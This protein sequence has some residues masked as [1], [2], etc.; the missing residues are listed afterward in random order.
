M[1]GG[2]DSPAVVV[3]PGYRIPMTVRGKDYEFDGPA[4]TL[5]N[6][7]NPMK[8]CGPFVHDD[9]GGRPAAIFGGRNK[10]HFSGGSRTT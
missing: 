5:S 3:P 1:F 7:K 6:M 8:G 10:L 9:E 2:I 4:A